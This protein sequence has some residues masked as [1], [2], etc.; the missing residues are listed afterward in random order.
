[1]LVVLRNVKTGSGNDQGEK[2]GGGA[3]SA[4]ISGLFFLAS[5]YPSQQGHCAIDE[6][7]LASHTIVETNSVL[8]LLFFYCRYD[9][10]WILLFILKTFLSFDRAKERAP[11]KGPNL[12]YTKRCK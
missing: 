12:P 5:C 1:M 2:P 10:L 8:S 9:I 4:V 7:R 11:E 3:F 6:V